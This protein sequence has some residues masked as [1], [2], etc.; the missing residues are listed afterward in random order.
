MTSLW[1]YSSFCGAVGGSI[2]NSLSP[3]S[4]W[5]LLIP[6]RTFLWFPLQHAWA[7]FAPAATHQW[8]FNKSNCK[9]ARF[10][11]LLFILEVW[12]NSYK[13]T[14]WE[15]HLVASYLISAVNKSWLK[16]NIAEGYWELCFFIFYSLILLFIA[17][18]N[19]S[20]IINMHSNAKLKMLLDTKGKIRRWFYRKS[21][22]SGFYQKT[23]YLDEAEV[24]YW[25]SAHVTVDIPTHVQIHILELS[26]SHTH[27]CFKMWIS[28]NLYFH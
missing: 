12:R 19:Q 22:A 20:W 23:K 11:L 10:H 16:R 5:T 13:T 28:I 27:V 21:I 25:N 4:S 24:P 18:I 1:W 8:E 26:D 14:S 3:H 17:F 9:I 6:P 7:G 15:I 2:V